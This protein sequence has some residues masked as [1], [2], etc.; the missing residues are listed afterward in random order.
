MSLPDI[1]IPF[2]LPLDIPVGLHPIIVHFA[3]AVPIIILLLELINLIAR[4]RALSVFSLFLMIVVGV[5][6]A[7]AYFTGIADGKEASTLLSPEGQNALKEHKLIGTYLVYITGAMILLKLLFMLFS[8]VIA[9]L[10]YIFILIG[11]IALVLVQGEEGGEL[12]YTYGANNK[13]VKNLLEAKEELQDEYDDLKDESKSSQQEIKAKE[14]KK[15]AV[16]TPEPKEESK[17]TE[18]E[19]SNN[20]EEAT[21]TE[22]EPKKEV[23]QEEKKEEDTKSEEAKKE[24]TKAVSLDIPENTT[25]QK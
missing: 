25:P 22:E 7:S 15:E 16:K 19:A 4:K 13:A 12:V 17:A 1:T 11:F 6:M 10:F 14:P 20:K 9:K 3:V 21:V 8:N 24:E 23:T 5:A 2:N 18:S